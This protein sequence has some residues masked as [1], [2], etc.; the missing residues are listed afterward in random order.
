MVELLLTLA[1]FATAA[2]SAVVGMGGGMTLLAV[3]TAL[4]APATVVPIH[5]LVQLTSNGTRT[6]LFLKH[7]HWGITAYY[8]LPA[9]CGVAIGARIYLGS[10]L[11]W[12][13]PAVGAFILVYLLT[14]SRKPRLRRLPIY[15]F[16]PLGFVVGTL[17]SLIGATGPLIAP[18]FVRDDLSK[19]QVI[20]TK[21]TVQ[22]GTH[23]AKL[24]AFFLLGFDY[25]AHIGVVLPLMAAAVLGTMFGKR[26]LSKLSTDVFRRLF[27]TVLAAIALYLL[28][29]PLL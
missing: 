12:F 1:A 25:T 2:F 29:S 15:T 20:A 6:L 16:A 11:P 8:V 10:E 5:G 4:M 27:V 24:P 14:L 28:A 13:R 19:E 3:M 23:L 7:V 17:A 9:I 21:A 22:I 26:Y 18:F